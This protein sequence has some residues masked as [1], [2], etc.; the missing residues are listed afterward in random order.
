MI[1][2]PTHH[3]PRLLRKRSYFLLADDVFKA[4]HGN[5]RGTA[6]ENRKKHVLRTHTRSPRRIRIFIC[7]FEKGLRTRRKSDF[8]IAVIDGTL[9]HR[10]ICIDVDPRLAERD[11][12]QTVL[13]FQHTVKQ[14]FAAY[15]SN[16][17]YAGNFLCG[18]DHFFKIFGIT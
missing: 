9:E 14:L 5:A 1:G 4:E 7:D 12:R 18:S 10:Q 6:F 2:H 13:H 17:I 16:V 3:F 8:L 15:I 11:I